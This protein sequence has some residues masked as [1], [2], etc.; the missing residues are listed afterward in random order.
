MLYGFSCL[1]VFIFGVHKKLISFFTKPLLI[2]IILIF[3]TFYLGM[4][5]LQRLEWKNSLIKSFNDL[6]KSLAKNINNQE[7]YEFIKIKA[8][9]TI[10]RNNKIFFPAKTNDGKAGMRLASEF[11]L[12][13]GKKILLDEGWFENS[14][15]DYFKNNNDIFK[16]NI[17]GYIRYP[18][19]PNLFTPDNNILKNQWYTYDLLKISNYFSSNLNKLYFIK[20][21]N[22]NK[23]NFLISSTFKHQFRNNHLQYAIT[24]FCMSFSFLILF[25]VYLKN[26]NKNEHII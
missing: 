24:W 22:L 13:N 2:S 6:E 8:N 5:Q 12:E 10:N 26:K 11:I 14:K 7:I 15:Y 21:T 23:E 20:K 3:T 17:E 4:W 18:R 19:D 16:E 9:G 25:L 1:Y